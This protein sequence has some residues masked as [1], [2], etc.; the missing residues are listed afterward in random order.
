M[1]SFANPDFAPVVLS[2]YSYSGQGH[3]P[4]L[5]DLEAELARA[6]EVTVPTTIIRGAQDPLETPAELADDGARF[7][8]IE[9]AITW[10]D[11]GHFAHREKPGA[12][13]GVLLRGE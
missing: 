3:D 10:E 6:P 12:L 9:D 7:A 1:P 2:G 4:A 11:A 5:A 8:V 13:V